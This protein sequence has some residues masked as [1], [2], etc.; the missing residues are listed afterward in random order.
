[1]LNVSM[2]TAGNLNAT[3]GGS[4]FEMNATRLKLTSN[5]S[6]LEIDAN[7]I[8]LNGTRIDFN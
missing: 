4:K 3:V 1:V 6:A 8:R 5:G 2:N 7:G